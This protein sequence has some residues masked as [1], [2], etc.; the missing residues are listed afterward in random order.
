MIVVKNV[1]KTLGNKKVVDNISFHI[2]PFECAGIIGKNGAGKTTLLNMMSGILKADCGFIRISD[3]KDTLKDYATLKKLAYV[4]G[5]RSQLWSDM[6]LIYSFDNCRKMYGM[7]KHD[8]TVRLGMLTDIFDIKDCLHKSVHHLS[9]GQKARSELVY[10]LLPEPEILF[11]DEAMI[12][13]DVSVKERVMSVI[14]ELKEN[15]KTTII[16]TS[17]NLVEVEKLCDRIIL[18]DNGTSIYDGSVEEIM[19]EFAPEYSID[20]EIDGAFPDMEDLPVEKYVMDNNILS[21]KFQKQKVETAAI[22]RHITDRCVIK[23]IKL[24]EPNL[25]DTIKKIYEGK[26]KI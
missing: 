8:F 6:K 18:I 4:S 9:L 25:E 17:H 19:K 24:R 23:N 15:R 12:G 2:A 22:I 21:I 13:L 5:T 11:L 1:S 20:F 7:G 14:N 16:Y 26:G 10:A 3:C